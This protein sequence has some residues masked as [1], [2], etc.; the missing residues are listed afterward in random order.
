MASPSRGTQAFIHRQN[1][2]HN[3]KWIRSEL[4]SSDFFCAMVKAN[5]YG[6][7]AAKISKWCEEIGFT[8]LG[9]VSIEEAI[10]IRKAGVQLPILLFGIA[11]EN[12]ESTFQEYNIEVVLSDFNDIESITFAR[13]V[14]VNCHLHFNTGMNRMGFQPEEADRLFSIL[15]TKPQLRVVGICTHFL[16]SE[17]YGKN[18]FTDKQLEVFD[19]IMQKQNYERIPIH[20]MNSGAALEERHKYPAKY[21]G[22]RLGISLYG[23]D[24]SKDLNYQAQLS[25]VMEIKSRLVKVLTVTKGDT[26]S[27]GASWEAKKTTKVAVVAIGY[28]DGYSRLNSN[29]AYMLVQGKKCNVIGNVTMDYTM[30]DVSELKTVFIGEEVV[31]LGEMGE[32][33]VTANDLARWGNTIS[34]EILTSISSRV[35][36]VY[37]D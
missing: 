13:E 24:P 33:Q 19:K 18:G 26:V 23:Y 30:I 36:R 12:H 31:V 2:F 22:Y 29:K 7:G 16:Q 4:R 35:P 3:A 5:A 6:H 15:K 1:F 21:P 8:S 9:V 32:N 25:P 20:V 28:A 10:E 17:D 37:V 27:Y 14:T 11:Y 34:Y